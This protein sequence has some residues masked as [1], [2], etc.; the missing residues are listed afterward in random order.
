[1][2]EIVRQRWVEYTDPLE[3]TVP[4]PYT[5]SIGLV[6]IWRG[7]LVDVPLDAPADPRHLV[8]LPLRRLDGSLATDAEK[9]EAYYALR[10]NREAAVHGHLYARQLAPNRLRLAPEDGERLES[11][12]LAAN[13]AILRQTF[14]GFD[15]LHACTQLVLH[16]LS[17]AM[18][19]Y[20]TRKFPKFTA[21]VLAGNLA[22]CHHDEHGR[23]VITGGAASESDIVPARGTVIKRNERQRMLLVNATKRGSKDRIDWLAEIPDEAAPEPPAAPP[24]DRPAHVLE[25]PTR[26]TVVATK[27]RRPPR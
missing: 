10:K 18:G 3:G 23:L 1:M 15:E 7:N 27:P 5:D 9:A 22:E 12:R 14:P 6:T 20:F 17:W 11:A 4:Y 16:S 26:D 8:A 2:R 24:A 21:H 13:E 25:L 19:P